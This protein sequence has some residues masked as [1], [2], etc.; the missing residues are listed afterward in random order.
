MFN[1][2]PIK[3]SSKYT[4]IFNQLSDANVNII[5]PAQK[6][7]LKEPEYVTIKLQKNQ[8]IILPYGWYF[9]ADLPMQIITLDDV[10]S[11]LIFRSS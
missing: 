3:A 10:F 11:K 6:N 8:V 4:L 2:Q 5:H 1:G 9:Y 7:N